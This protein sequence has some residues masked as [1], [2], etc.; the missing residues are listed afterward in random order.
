MKLSH[1][2][3]TMLLTGASMAQAGVLT[4]T[5]TFLPDAGTAGTGS[6][7]AVIT[8]D[9]TTHVLNYAGDFSGL[10][11]TSTQAH[12]HC[13]TA[14]PLTGTS[15]I[16]VDS[17]SLLGFPI[18][19][20]LGTFDAS[21]DLDDPANFNAA[22]LTAAGNSTD[23]AISRVIGGFTDHTSYMNIHSTTFQGGEIRG[24]L[25]AVPE[26]GSLALLA[27]GLGVLGA[28]RRRGLGS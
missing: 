6:G 12:F 16:A 10:S 19:V 1:A 18:G 28:V 24:F 9:N 8:F 25:V 5:T 22:F 27:L 7:S 21:L 3:A 20:T 17:P 14:V 2:V 4:W 15:G 13:C 23:V 26:P 11:G